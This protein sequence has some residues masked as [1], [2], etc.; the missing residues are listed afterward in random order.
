[1]R[2]AASTAD[3]AISEALF[4]TAPHTMRHEKVIDKSAQGQ[5]P[6]GRRGQAFLSWFSVSLT[7]AFTPVFVLRVLHALTTLVLARMSI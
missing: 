5:D 2:R 6:G 3:S 4:V 1:M 7:T